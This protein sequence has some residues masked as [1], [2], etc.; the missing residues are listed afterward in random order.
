M[1][2][3]Q[4]YDIAALFEANERER[5]EIHTRYLNEQMVRVLRTIGY[6]VGFRRG[7]SPISL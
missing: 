3:R 2:E 7:V 6:D 1:L 5:F 4:N